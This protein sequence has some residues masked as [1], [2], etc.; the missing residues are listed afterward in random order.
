MI[1]DALADA[2]G[3]GVD[4]LDGAGVPTAGDLA[5]AAAETLGGTEGAEVEMSAAGP[6]SGPTCTGL[7]SLMAANTSS[8]VSRT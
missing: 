6:D 5:A 3:T 1:T 2:P 7:K 8:I 4:F